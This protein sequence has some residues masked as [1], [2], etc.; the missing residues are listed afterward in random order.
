MVRLLEGWARK[1][2]A[3]TVRDQEKQRLV[4]LLDDIGIC[5]FNARLS[6]GLLP[7]DT[8]REVQQEHFRKCER[9]GPVVTI[10]K[11]IFS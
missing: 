3:S 2:V 4:V 9:Q 6:A 8:A 10:L 5:R 11:A 7:E 1:D